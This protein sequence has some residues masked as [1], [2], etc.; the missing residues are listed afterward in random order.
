[1]ILR[2]FP[3]TRCTMLAILCTCLGSAS[4]QQISLSPPPAGQFVLDYAELIGA[5]DEA[6]LNTIAGAVLGEKAIPII[7]VTIEDMARYGGA[8]LRIETFATLLYNQWEIGHEELG[9]QYWN[10]GVLLLVSRDDRHARIELGD[11]WGREQDEI[12]RQ[13][14]DQR[15]VANFKRNDFGGGIVHGVEA[16]SSMARGVELPRKPID[17]RSVAV[18]IAFIGLAAFTVFSLIRKG[19]SGWAWLFW[20][21]VFAVL[22]A[23]LLNAMRSGGRGGGGFSGGS[24]GGGFSSGGGATGSW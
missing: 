10:K 5:E 23:V 22:G 1:M 19:A 7:T 12:A 21:T 4:A 15:I 18:L 6:K 13:I 20:G 16:L 17:W 24:F 9:G 8:G 2:Q 14:M 11:G 3:Y